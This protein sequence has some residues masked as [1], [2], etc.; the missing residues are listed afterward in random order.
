MAV[1]GAGGGIGGALATVQAPPVFVDLVCLGERVARVAQKG[2]EATPEES[3]R[4]SVTV[5]AINAVTRGDAFG[6]LTDG[7]ERYRVL[8]GVINT[9][10]RY[11][12]A[13]PIDIEL[14]RAE[15]P[16]CGSVV[17]LNSAGA[18]LPSTAVLDC[19]VEYLHAEAVVGGY[20]IAEDR[21]L[22]LESVYRRASEIFGGASDNWAFVESAT[23][24]WNAAFSSLRFKPGDRVLTTRA[25]YPSN[26]GGLLRAQEI[27]GVEIVVVPDDEDGQVDVAALG[28]LLD[29]RTRLVSLTHVPTQGGLINPA[30]CVGAILRD[31]PILYQLDACQ[32]VGQMPVNVA[33]IGCDVL[34][35]TGRKFLRGPRGTGMVWA[36]DAALEQM[37]NPAGVDMQG[38]T[39][40]APMTITPLPSARRFEPYEVFFAGKV[41]L[42]AALEYA[43]AIGINEIAARNT[44][45]S[46]RLRDGLE[47]LPGV[48]IHDKGSNKSAIVT[49]T[50]QGHDSLD[51]RRTLRKMSINVSTSSQTSARLDFPQRGLD[52][53]VR[54]S[55]HYYN[56]TTE[57]DAL[58]DAIA[59][60]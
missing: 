29:E 13:M 7:F 3:R 42:A 20:E 21:A 15:T 43:A 59:N 19:V 53:V 37:S 39:W 38:S 31:T 27:Q 30:E 24:G 12:R 40:E 36:S 6:T 60:L 23:R 58:V 26:M 4:M 2:C 56:T 22:A 45:L 10:G 1:T 11:R 41:G 34:S 9:G 16:G 28:S 35:F 33:E 54:A 44:E 51:L 49:F 25:E 32:S 5:P 48:T 47:D 8:A 18:S 52:K 14:V 17:H 46:T 50:V 55:V 57:I